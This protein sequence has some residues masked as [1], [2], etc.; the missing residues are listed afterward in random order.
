LDQPSD[1]IPLTA[2]LDGTLPTGLLAQA[3][4]AKPVPAAASIP[5][6]STPTPVAI[7][8]LTETRK[9]EKITVTGTPSSYR[10]SNNP[11]APHSFQLRDAAGS[12]IRVAVWDD[13]YSKLSPAVTQA[14]S[15]GQGQLE[16]QT[17]VAVFRN[18]VEL[19]LKDAAA[20]KVA[21]APAPAPTQATSASAPAPD[22]VLAPGQITRNDIGKTVPVKA[23]VESAR[24]PSTERAPFVLRLT[25]E[26]NGPAGSV[27]LVFWA[28]TKEAIPADHQAEVGDLVEARGK[29]DEHRGALQLRLEGPATL[30]VLKRAGTGPASSPKP[31]S[32]APQPPTISVAEL[33]AHVGKL[34]VSVQ[35]LVV[36]SE[37]IRFG[38]RLQVADPKNL[39]QTATVLFYDSALTPTLRPETGRTIT[40]SGPVMSLATGDHALVVTQ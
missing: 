7:A 24:R 10:A 31:S 27:D 36:S 33:P 32:S 6:P 40:L 9:G 25:G 15:Q 8:S 38:T 37:P 1:A 3:T 39:S 2:A 14:I 35:A 20:A 28:D 13:V 26:P 21:G 18:A 22:G 11:R 17:E 16:L 29:V 4:T 30:K 19:H 5:T 12:A 34:P 23:L